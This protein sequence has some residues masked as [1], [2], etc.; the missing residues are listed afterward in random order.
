MAERK[1]TQSRK[2]KDGDNHPTL[3]PVSNLVAACE[4]RRDGRSPNF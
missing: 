3:Q 2:A 4:G 1:V